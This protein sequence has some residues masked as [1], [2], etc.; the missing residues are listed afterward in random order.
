MK[1]MIIESVLIAFA[2]FFA[3]YGIITNRAGTGSM[4]YVF[5]ILFSLLI[6]LITAAFHF[7]VISKLPTFLKSI[8]A[9]FIAI[10]VVSFAVIEGFIIKDFNAAPKAGLDYIIVLGAQVKKDGP[11]YVLQ[12]RLDK[13]KDYLTENPTT[14]CIVS[15]G[16]GLNEPFSEAEGMAKYLIEQGISEDR[17]IKED[18]SQSTKENII[19]SSKY[20]E[21][22]ASV[23]IITNNFHMFRALQISRK[24]GVGNISGISAKSNTL[25]LLNNM[26][27]EYLAEIKFLILG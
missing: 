26:V 5:W 24:Y 11:S 4:F 15:G 22:D 8:A 27:R 12:Y 13:A 23:G 6:L 19:N 7:G 9:V 3:I 16:Q 25:F 2:V 10:V 14:K 17:I 21:S 20:I 1:N 18:K